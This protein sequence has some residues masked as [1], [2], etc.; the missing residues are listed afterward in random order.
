M[1]F[2]VCK[3]NHVNIDYIKQPQEKNEK[4]LNNKKY[5]IRN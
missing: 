3:L 5:D 4:C 2:A 1:E